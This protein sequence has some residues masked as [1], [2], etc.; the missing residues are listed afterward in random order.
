MFCP[1]SSPDGSDC[2]QMVSSLHWMFQLL[3]K[4]S[5]CLWVRSDDQSTT[6]RI[7]TSTDHFYGSISSRMTWCL[8][9][10]FVFILKSYMLFLIFLV[11]PAASM[12]IALKMTSTGNSQAHLPLS[13]QSAIRSAY[14]R[15]FLKIFF[16]MALSAS[17]I[18]GT[19]TL[20][21]VI[22]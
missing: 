13:L 22:G 9:L 14:L 18:V 20:C 15:L 3:T 8:L 1:L 2:H 5:F 11:L 17:L 21:L 6:R 10:L 7:L 4:T 16:P 19:L 12:L